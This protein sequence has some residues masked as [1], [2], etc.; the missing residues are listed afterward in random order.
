MH[1]FPCQIWQVPTPQVVRCISACVYAAL[2][3]SISEHSF[4]KSAYTHEVLRFTAGTFASSK[5][6]SVTGRGF[7]SSRIKYLAPI[8]Y[9]AE[10]SQLYRFPCL[11]YTQAVISRITDNCSCSIICKP[12]G[13]PCTDPRY[14]Y[15]IC[16]VPDVHSV[17]GY[18]VF[19]TDA[20]SVSFFPDIFPFISR[21]SKTI[22]SAWFSFAYFV[23]APAIFLPSSM[24]RRFA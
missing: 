2:K 6:L 14:P 23:T 10:R 17:S 19:S 16:Y 4:L 20:V 1:F 11:E 18:P 21:Y 7:K 8:L 12:A 9:D 15:P 3:S 24:F 13:I 5:D 22:T